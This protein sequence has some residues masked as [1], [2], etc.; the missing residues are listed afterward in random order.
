MSCLLER[1]SSRR[2]VWRT[3]DACKEGEGEFVRWE[4]IYEPSC[5]EHDQITYKRSAVT[6]GGLV[7]RCVALAPAFRDNVCKISMIYVYNPSS[8]CC[9]LYVA[10]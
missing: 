6:R 5:T 8:G 1:D 9:C 4:Y 7:L 10:L 3:L 2:L